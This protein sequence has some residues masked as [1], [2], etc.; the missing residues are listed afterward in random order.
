MAISDDGNTIAVS[1]NREDSAA[2]GID[3][4]QNSN[5][6]SESG[7]VYVFAWTGATWQQQAYIKASNTGNADLFGTSV[8][9]SSDGHTLAVG[10]REE[11]S[12]A[13]GVDPPGGAIASW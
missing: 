6:V 3:G 9:L 4:D 7:A 10:A 2:I 12:G 5:G 13:I 11:D 1:A 8:A